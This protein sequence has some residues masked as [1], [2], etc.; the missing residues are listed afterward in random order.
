LRVGT[1]DAGDG[2]TELESVSIPL[3]ISPKSLF[4]RVNNLTQQSINAQLGNS[5]S[6]IIAH[7]PRF[8]SA[9]NEVGALHFEPNQLVY[10]SLQNS[11]DL[12]LNSIDIDLVYDNETYAEC[13]SGK[14]IVVLH[15][16][17]RQV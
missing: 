5:Y 8:D 13:L 15:I 17:K 7:L 6:K 14:S 11:Q 12:Y 10:V 16:R 3:L 9:G 2:S 4:V 1:F